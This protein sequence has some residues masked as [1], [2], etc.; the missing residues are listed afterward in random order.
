VAQRALPPG[1]IR[2]RSFF[3]LLDADGWTTAF[4]KALFWFG[5]IVLLLGYVPDRAYYFT[6]SPTLDVGYNAISPINFCDSGNKTLPCPAP[7]GAFVPWEP[8]QPGTPLD[9]PAPRIGGSAVQSGENLYIVGGNVNGQP[10]ADVVTTKVSTD[11]NLGGW[12]A[13]P[14][15]PEPRASAAIVSLSGVPYVI[16]GLDAAGKA[17]DSVFRGT[18]DKGTLTGWEKVDALKLPR[19]LSDASAVATG[20]G[21]YLLGGRADGAPVA[22]V[23]RSILDT[24]ANLQAWQEA[25][26]L[27]MPE[28]RAGAP[29]VLNG[30]FI[31][32][33][34]GEGPSGPTNDI[35]RLELDSKGGPR[36]DAAGGWA[37]PQK[38]QDAA[39]L[40]APRVAPTSYA[41]NSAIYVIGGSDESGKP[42]KTTYWAVP[43]AASGN[44]TEWKHLDQIDLPQPR[45]GGAISV[46]GSF[47]FLI[48]GETPDGPQV[49]SLRANVSP[50]PPFFRLGMFGA[51]IPALSI[52]GEIGQQLGYINAFTVGLVNFTL[53]IIIG[54]TFSHPRGTR[55]VLSKLTRGRIKPLPPE[56]VY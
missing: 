14:A 32:V 29:A 56:E 2:R 8:S 27:V 24:K 4:I 45:R 33:L 54:L 38:N 53:L 55:K 18:L 19:A 28:P 30:K 1:A 44:I 6:V 42:V 3:G 51:T 35:Y 49:G 23:Y 20:S 47:S 11:G 37:E 25:V 26:A 17:T 52:K 41:A 43:D 48:G 39:R 13:G 50:K 36:L 16:G 7:P 21:F 40:P 22:T 12:A 5:V 34:G 9:L 31:Y 15:L 46:V 10:T